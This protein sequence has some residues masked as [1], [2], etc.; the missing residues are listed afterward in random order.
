MSELVLWM[1]DLPMGDDVADIC[2]GAGRVT[3]ICIR[4]VTKK[5]GK[6]FDLVSGTDLRVPRERMA[7]CHHFKNKRCRIIIMAPPCTAYGRFTSVYASQHPERQAERL[8]WYQPITD[9]CADIA[10]LQLERGDDFLIE[11]PNGSKL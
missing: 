6:N 8:D 2:G 5:T 11:Q 10:W 3:R 9:L 4:R 1:R 7:A